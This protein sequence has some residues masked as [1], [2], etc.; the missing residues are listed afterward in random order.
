MVRVS[1]TFSYWLRPPA[2][3]GISPEIFVVAE[4]NNCELLNIAINKSIALQIKNV[5]EDIQAVH[6][7]SLSSFLALPPLLL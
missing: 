7:F 1:I 5:K 3:S 2:F 4:H 6:C